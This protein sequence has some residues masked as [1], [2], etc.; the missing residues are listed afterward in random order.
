[1]PPLAHPERP[2]HPK[3]ATILIKR[4]W[5]EGRVTWAEHSERRTRER[6]FD[7]LEVEE[8]VR[9]GMVVG[10]GSR[11]QGS[12]KY[13]LEDRRRTK[14]LVMSILGDL[15]EIVTIIRLER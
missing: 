10:I 6:E 4:L 7:T 5:R 2:L 1:M 11:S 13:E 12:W 14:R 15:L 9:N 8:L 3:H